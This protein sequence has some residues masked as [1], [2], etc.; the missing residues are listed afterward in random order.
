MWYGKKTKN[1]LITKLVDR[2][3]KHR[4]KLT[5]TAMLMEIYNKAAL[6]KGKFKS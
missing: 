2:E 3:Q 1:K 6:D 5:D 4:I